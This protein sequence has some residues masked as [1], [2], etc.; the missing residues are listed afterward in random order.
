MLKAKSLGITSSLPLVLK[1][2]DENPKYKSSTTTALRRKKSKISGRNTIILLSDRLFKY[3]PS[4][5]KQT[6][7]PP[8]WFGKFPPITRFVYIVESHPRDTGLCFFNCFGFRVCGNIAW[9]G[10]RGNYWNLTMNYLFDPQPSWQGK[11]GGVTEE[12]RYRESLHH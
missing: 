5:D 8:Y 7:K 12:I 2:W 3:I 6:R 9:S 11:I 1:P 4:L 10:F